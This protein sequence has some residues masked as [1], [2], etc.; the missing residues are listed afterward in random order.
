MEIEQL[1][2]PDGKSID[3][4][5]D[6]LLESIQGNGR[7][8]LFITVAFQLC[9]ST[10]HYAFYSLAYMELMQPFLCNDVGSS[11]SYSCV[12]ADFCSNDLIEYTVDWSSERAFDN[13]V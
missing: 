7:F 2:V 6:E 4:R 9:I 1:I 3:E 11:E 5:F 8:Q 10:V 12:P 13:W